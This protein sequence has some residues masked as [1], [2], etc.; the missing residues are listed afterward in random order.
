[1]VLT[2]L[3]VRTQSAG[4]L[5]SPPIIMIV[6]SGGGGSVAYQAGGRYTSSSRCLNPDAVS[7]I[8]TGTSVP[9]AGIW[10]CFCIAVT[11]TGSV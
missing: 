8:S 3:P 2:A 4:V 5:N 11:A 10:C 7:A 9:L 1:M 6:G